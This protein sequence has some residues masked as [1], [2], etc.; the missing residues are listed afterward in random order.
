MNNME[1][2]KTKLKLTKEEEQSL[3]PS[4]I[5]LGMDLVNNKDVSKEDA[6]KLYLYSQQNLRMI[7]ER[8]ERAKDNTKVS[9]HPITR[10][11]L[12]LF[13]ATSRIDL[14]AGGRRFKTEDEAINYLLD[15]VL[16]LGVNFLDE[17]YGNFESVTGSMPP[18]DFDN[19][20]KR[21][22]EINGE[23][24]NEKKD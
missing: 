15:V 11:K 7:M 8:I 3:T 13:M 9:I 5:A 17:I 6:V 1:Q 16:Q 21:N 20:K 19:P 24:K 22:E 4:L 10:D 14:F 18:E 12:K 23:F 2:N